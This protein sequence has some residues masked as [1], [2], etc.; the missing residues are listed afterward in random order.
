MGMPVMSPSHSREGI[1]KKI[2]KKNGKGKT[3]HIGVKHL[4]K[5]QPYAAAK[6]SQER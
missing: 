3:P 4:E 6:P 2:G 5:I 1:T